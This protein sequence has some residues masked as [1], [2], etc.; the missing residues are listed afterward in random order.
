MDRQPA[1][2]TLGAATSGRPARARRAA[3]LRT[4]VLATGA[5]LLVAG[6]GVG[7]WVATRPSSS[8]SSSGGTLEIHTVAR[9]SFDISTT[10]SGELEAKNQIEIRSK[11]DSMSTIVE[12]VDE[13]KTV[14]SGDVLIRLNSD[15]LQS[16]IRE[17][18]LQKVQAQSDVEAAETE[19]KVQEKENDAKLQA[20][21][22][23]V[24]I[25]V[26]SLKQWEEGELVQKHKD[27]TQA[28]EKSEAERTR[29]KEKYDKSIELEHEGFVSKDELKRDK[30]AYDDAQRDYDKAVLAEQIYDKYQEPKDRTSKTSDLT[31]ARAEFERVKEQNV[32]ELAGKT[33]KRETRRQQLA[34]HE[35]KLKKYNEQLVNSTIKAPSDGLVVYSTSMERMMWG[36]GGEGPLQIGRQVHPNELLIVLPDTSVMMASVQVHESLASKI[37]PGLRA[38]VKVDAA[39]GKTYTGTVESIGVLAES[40]GWRDPNLREYRVKIALDLG[41]KPAP[42]PVPAPAGDA[43]AAPAA[44][45]PSAPSAT[46]AVIAAAPAGN[47]PAAPA[48]PAPSATPAVIAVAPAAAPDPAP[49]SAA[50]TPAPAP[51]PAAPA[52]AATVAAA[53]PATS[54]ADSALKPSMRCEAEIVMGKV[55]DATAVPIQAVFNEGM[56]R[57]VYVP[58]GSSKYARRPIKL[59]RLSERFAEI[60]SGLA[61][62]ERVLL[63]EPKAGEVLDRPWSDKELAAVGLKKGENGQLVPTVDSPGKGQAKHKGGA[64]DQAKD[65]VAVAPGEPV[66]IGASDSTP[67][68]KSATPAVEKPAADPAPA[69]GKVAEAVPVTK[70]PAPAPAPEKKSDG[71]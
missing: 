23:K 52:S 61:P 6:A 57:Y 59:G 17:E 4:A 28:I 39:G 70:A 56:L 15:E 21:D 19:L 11:L 37:K 32:I 51:V 8:P 2:I 58:E 16:K 22:V 54:A 34:M 38:T 40:G 13:G 20:A 44:P 48:P 65:A 36:W 18:D 64:H 42:A 41:D 66:M 46:P 33:S 9:T 43:A 30:L 55:E 5:L 27:N 10:C 45:A 14:K 1:G 62:D 71:G 68:P 26:L 69:P 7:I 24:Q 12:L 29:L 67:D 35:D 53:K 63:R 60:V 3:A 25:A 49:A 50:A 47:T 31:Q